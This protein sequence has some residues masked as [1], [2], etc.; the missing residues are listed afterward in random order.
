M[1][2]CTQRNTKTENKNDVYFLSKNDLRCG[3]D[4]FLAQNYCNMKDSEYEPK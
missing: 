4:K 3:R 2:R 1:D